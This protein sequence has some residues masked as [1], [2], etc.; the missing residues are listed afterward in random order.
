MKKILASALALIGVSKSVVPDQKEQSL[1]PKSIL[2]SMPTLSNDLAPVEHFEGEPRDSD[3]AFHEDE[4]SQIEFFPQSQLAAVQRT[5]NEYKSFEA[6]NR[7]EYGW[8]NIYVRKLERTAVVGGPRAVHSIE[9]AFHAKAGPA[10]VLFSS[11]SIIGQVTD[12]FSIPLGGS[13]FLYGYATDAGI[14]ILGALVGEN[15][16]HQILVKAFVTLNAQEGLVLADWRQQLMLISAAP[17]G[18]LDMWRP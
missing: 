6:A 13:I 10:P 11:S 5:M 12:G 8:R 4:W 15:P 14:P 9:A 1:D 3:V 16:D 18:D 17:S 7:A 2:F